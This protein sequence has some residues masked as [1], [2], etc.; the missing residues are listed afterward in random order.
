V[1]DIEVRDLTIPGRHG[2]VPAR[3]YRGPG[4]APRGFVWVHGG[5]FMSGSLDMPESD[6]VATAIA[7]AGIPVLALHYHLCLDGVHYPVPSDDVVDAWCWAVD[8][9]D[10]LGVGGGRFHLG[11]ASAGGTLAAGATK[12]LRDGEGTLPA[13]LVLAYPALH[14]EL[15]PISEELQRATAGTEIVLTPDIVDRIN[16]NYVG[17][18][19]LLADPYAFAANGDVSGQPP[20]YVLNSDADVLRSSGEE[21]ARQLAAAGVDVT[22]G[23]EPGSEH[24][25]LNQPTTEE[26]P[27]S[28]RRIVAWLRSH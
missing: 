3:Q 12:R 7:A 8:H 18:A 19:A 23:L 17:D 20:V 16:L 22:I 6:W 24:G 9:A 5:A 27:R 21:Y 2:A 15:P 25:H 26:A 10:D 13:S 14:P 4:S 28:I 11:G 1:T